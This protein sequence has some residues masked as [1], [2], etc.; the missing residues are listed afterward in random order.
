MKK[1]PAK[2]FVKVQVDRKAPASVKP[3]ATNGSGMNC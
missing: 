3:K 2:T 1:T